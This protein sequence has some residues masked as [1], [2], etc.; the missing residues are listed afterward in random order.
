MFIYH[1][2]DHV[3]VVM[4][5]TLLKNYIIQQL[6]SPCVYTVMWI[7]YFM[8]SSQYS[9]HRAQGCSYLLHVHDQHVNNSTDNPF[10]VYMQFFIHLCISSQLLP[11]TLT[12]LMLSY[13]DPNCILAK[14]AWTWLHIALKSF[15]CKQEQTVAVTLLLINLVSYN[16]LHVSCSSYSFNAYSNITCMVDNTCNEMMSSAFLKVNNLVSGVHKTL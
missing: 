7:K 14:Q 5:V 16:K 9:Q 8:L 10:V 4:N 2:R 13:T 11:M 3:M 6:L 15:K 1:M 12:C